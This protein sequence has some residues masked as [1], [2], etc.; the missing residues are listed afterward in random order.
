MVGLFHFFQ[1]LEP[2]QGLWLLSYS[3]LAFPGSLLFWGWLLYSGSRRGP[4]LYDSKS[5]AP[6]RFNYSTMT[7]D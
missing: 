7:D 5:I 1:P 2:R 4:G 6:L 3:M